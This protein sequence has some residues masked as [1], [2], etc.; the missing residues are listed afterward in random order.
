VGVVGALP[1]MIGS[2]QAL[3]TI[4]VLLGIGSS[5]RGRLLLADGL[6]LTFQDVRVEKDPDCPVCSKH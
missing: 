4:K 6:A 3:E 5:A 2:L 1:G